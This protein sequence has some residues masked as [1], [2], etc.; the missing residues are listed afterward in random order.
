MTIKEYEEFIRYTVV[1][2]FP[3]VL[4][5][6][7]LQPLT[8]LDG[9]PDIENQDSYCMG[10]YLYSPNGSVYELKNDAL[11]VYVTFDGLL[12]RVRDHSEL[13]AEYLS[14]LVEWLQSKSLGVIAYPTLGN[15]YR[16]DAYD[17][18]NGFAVLLE[19][20]VDLFHDGMSC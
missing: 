20:S 12:D 6:K 14:V 17:A 8:Y 18:Y 3:A 7:K 16:V 4:E 1:N 13:S 15:A 11:K 19:S 2:E 10:I 9:V 5:E